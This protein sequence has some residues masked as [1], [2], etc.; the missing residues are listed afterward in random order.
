MNGLGWQIQRQVMLQQKN[1]MQKINITITGDVKTAK[2][3]ELIEKRIKNPTKPL[4]LASKEYLK[5]I[6]L[7][8][9]NKGRTFDSEGWP[10]LKDVT[11]A[12]KRKL[13][14]K[15]QSIAIETP[16]VRTGALRSGFSSKMQ[17]KNIS[18]IYNRMSYAKLHQEGGTVNFHGR[19]A[20]V[21]KRVLAAIDST[22]IK[23][24]TN[25]FVKWITSII[26]AKK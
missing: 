2:A 7:N 16:L 26:K 24:V 18:N 4:Q 10:K 23:M 14:A 8:F 15:G 12:E 17:G 6:T 13:Y 3:L 22:R 20:R 11:I 1:N 19:K 5:A 21:P 25:V 9:K